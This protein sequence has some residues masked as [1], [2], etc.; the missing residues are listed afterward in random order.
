MLFPILAKESP[1]RDKRLTKAQLA[2]QMEWS[3]LQLSNVLREGLQTSFNDFINT[4]RVNEVKECLKDP[5]NKDY[6]LLAIAEDCGFNSKT[7]FYR[8][9][10]RITGKT[11]SEYM[12]GMES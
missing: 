9:F 5:K 7:S 12:E 1:Y 11:P 3:E 10:K 4:Y 6:T 2:T 8:T